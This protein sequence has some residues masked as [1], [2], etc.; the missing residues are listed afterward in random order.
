[1]SDILLHLVVSASYAALGFV[2]WHGVRQLVD[3][4]RWQHFAL[5]LP[6]GLHAAQLWRT[7]FIGDAMY[8][9]IGTTISLIVWLTV[10]IYWASGFVYRLEGLQLLLIPGAA[11][12]SWLPLLL[13]PAHPLSNVHLSAFKAHLLISLAAYSLFTIASM[14]VVLMA[15]MEK[16]LHSARLPAFLRGMPPLLTM[17]ALLF[18]I[19]WAGFILLTLTLAS[20]IFFSES[21]FGK[22]LSFNHKTVFGI[23]SW[24]IF[25]ALLSGR[26][27]AGWRGRVAL[28]WTLAG[29]LALIL[30]YIGSK[31][32]LEIILHR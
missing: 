11:L 20:G 7:I 21:L 22:P 3:A 18:R 15:V 30:A 17:E 12:L 25:A 27:L 2:L 24:V 14:H 29:F 23:A 26:V 19:I 6:I 1:M 8:L 5:A 31:F 32:V 4:P 16:R 10:F 13:P 28:R 9:G